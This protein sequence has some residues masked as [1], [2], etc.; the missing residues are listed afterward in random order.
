MVG[1]GQNL[2][3]GNPPPQSTVKTRFMGNWAV[4]SG[5]PVESSSTFISPQVKTG[6]RVVAGLVAA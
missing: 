6:D 2:P 5:A 1:G 3:E 4:T